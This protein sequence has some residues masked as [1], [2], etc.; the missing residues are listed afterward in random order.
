MSLTFDLH[1]H[2]TASDGTLS[3]A[4]L[5]ARAHAAGVG[6]LAITDHDETGGVGEARAAAG[7]LGLHVVAGAEISVT[8][9]GGTVH[10]VALN[11]DPEAPALAQGL[12]EVREFRQWRAEEMGRRLEQRGIAGAYEGARA[13]ANGRIISRTHFA[14][15]LVQTGRSPDVRSVFKHY[16]KRNKPGHVPGR[17]APL[18]AAVGWV[19]EAGGQAVIAHPARYDM[20]AAR[21]RRLVGEFKECGGSGI[22][23]V[24]GSHTPEDVRLMARLANNFGLSASAGSD[25]HGPENPYVELGRL[26]EL[27]P[28]CTPIW[29]D[30]SLNKAGHSC[31][32][33]PLRREQE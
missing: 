26:P 13:L 15:F 32:P 18:E 30:W 22:E 16:L 11:I 29:S 7:P 5:V 33:D 28:E 1:S 19:L 21:L 20:T 12:A 9:N 17:W 25:F 24:S 10:V 8:W 6:V 31:G 4:Q 3:P 27:P 14:H 23:V 2:T